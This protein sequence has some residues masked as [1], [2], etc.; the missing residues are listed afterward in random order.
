MEG[1][2]SPRIGTWFCTYEDG[3]GRGNE[4]TIQKIRKKR[5]TRK[6]E[7]N[8]GKKKE[9]KGKQPLSFRKMRKGKEKQ[10][11]KGSI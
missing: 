6:E 9:S 2:L 7:E 5:T 10:R 3:K 1:A 4:E 11:R 8:I